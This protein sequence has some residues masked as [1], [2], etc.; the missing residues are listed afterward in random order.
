MYLKMPRFE[1][2][3]TRNKWRLLFT[4]VLAVVMM[5]PVATTAS[6]AGSDGAN[7]AAVQPSGTFCAEGMVIDHEEEPIEE[8]WFVVATPYDANGELDPNGAIVADPSTEDDEEGQFKFEEDGGLYAGLWQFKLEGYQEG[9][10][11]PVTADVFDVPLEVGND[12]CVRIRFKLRRVVTVIVIKI[13]ADHNLLEDWTI[14]ATPGSGN[15]FAEEQDEVTNVN[16]EA[17]FRLTE[18]LWVF[19]EEPPEDAEYGYLPVVPFDG[20]QELDIEYQE[21]PIVIRF[22]NELDYGG[23]IEVIKRDVPPDGAEFSEPFELA[24]WAI[25][26][27]RMDGTEATFGYTDATGTIKFENLPPG[28]YTVVEDDRVGWESVTP[29]EFEV[30]VK[31]SP[32]CA[33]VE[34]TNRQVEPTFCIEGRKLDANGHYGLPDWEIT[35]EPLASGGYE[36]DDV[37]TNGLGEYRFDLPTDD[38]RIPGSRYEIC[39]EDKDGWLPHTRSCYTVTVPHHPGACV[40]VPDFVNQQVGHTES[41][42]DHGWT[43]PI[44]CYRTHIVQSGE[45][46]Y[47]IGS[48]YGVSA[49]AMVNAN[50]WVR[51]RPHHYLYVGDRVCIPR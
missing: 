2:G 10:W 1:G 51:S 46:L 7:G 28:P 25:S 27:L 41:G 11:E 38:Y 14:F 47:A 39:E 4:V 22:K 5:I 35:A 13:D 18:G 31:N 20:Y 15:Y 6:A 44:S 42:K 40:Q 32:D 29:S 48:H 17:I 16:G 21:E 24:G 34:F 26:V 8:G 9:G 37:F 36:L 19:T 33:V 50:P 30:T 43:G 23:C 49:Q 12:D 45:G 3:I